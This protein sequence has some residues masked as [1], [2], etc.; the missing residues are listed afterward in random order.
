MNIIFAKDILMMAPYYGTILNTY[1]NSSYGLNLQDTQM[2]DGLFVQYLN[3]GLGCINAF[4]FQ[5][6]QVNFSRVIG[7]HSNADMYFGDG[8]KWVL[9]LGYDNIVI[10]MDAGNNISGLT[11]FK[12]DNN[13]KE[14]YVRFGKYISIGEWFGLITRLLPYIGY[15]TESVGG[16]VTVDP[17][18]PAPSTAKPIDDGQNY[19]LAGLNSKFSFLH[20]L[21]FDAK[22]MVM[23]QKVK[24][25][26]IVTLQA[27]LF[28][29][30][31]WGIS[32]QYKYMELSNGKDIYNIAGIDYVF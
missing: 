19:L 23:F 1:E 31:N 9:G 3:S 4:F 30:Q 22:Y 25:I 11:S 8:D 20:F 32:Y 27:N 16:S 12:M 24:P 13:V 10:K 14:V 21:N 28:L 17:A 18:G 7:V 2:M 26:N 15:G 6:P 5:A 29:T